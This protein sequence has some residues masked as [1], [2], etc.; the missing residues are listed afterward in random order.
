MNSN[1]IPHF[2]GGNVRHLHRLLSIEASSQVMY[3]FI[4]IITESMLAYVSLKVEI[5]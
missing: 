1:C 4:L 2:Q 3:H 5:F